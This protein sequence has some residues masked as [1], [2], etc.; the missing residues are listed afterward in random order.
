MT[1]W[2]ELSPP[3]LPAPRQRSSPAS[4]V[5]ATL[6]V[7]AALWWGQTFLIPLT[8]GLM[9]ALLVMPVTVRLTGWLRSGVLATVLTLA[10]VLAALAVGAIAFGGQFMRVAQRA[11]DM[12]SLAAQR[13]AATEPG[14]GSVLTRGHDALQELDLAA[15][16][17]IA[18]QGRSGPVRRA[19]A[20]AAAR[21]AAAADLPNDSLTTG[22]TAALRETAVTSSGA[23]LGFAGTISVIFFIAFFVLAGGRNLSRQV[24]ALWRHDAALHSRASIALAECAR[25]I[26]IY[27]GVLMVTNGV[28]GIAVWLAFSAVGLP[29]AAG[30]GATAAILHVVPYLGM[31]VLTVLGAAET[32]LAYGTIG[33]AMAM[34]TFLIVLSSLI[35]TLMAAWLQ[36]RAAKVSPSALFIGLVFWGSLWGIWG[37]FLGPALVV[38]LKVAAEQSRSGLRFA[39]LMRG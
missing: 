10:L 24:L 21:R 29:D 39:N 37:L 6:A 36:G 16:R 5:I 8:A 7:I 2:A 15:D 27:G 30:W 14:S 28:V 11:P 22:A 18:P 35:G 38:I 31:A 19:A 12:I 3:P 9:L 25:Q 13:V 34:A 17:A 1:E 26:R 32:F 23:V 20:K 4:V 33:A